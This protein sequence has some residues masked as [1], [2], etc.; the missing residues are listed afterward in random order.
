[1]GGKNGGPVSIVY[2]PSSDLTSPG[3]ASMRKA[4]R[5]LLSLCAASTGALKEYTPGAHV[6]R[7]AA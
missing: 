3:C 1:M 6:L 4:S 7:I 2:R 5:R